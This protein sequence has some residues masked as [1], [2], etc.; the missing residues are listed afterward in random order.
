MCVALVETDPT[1]ARPSL[2]IECTPYLFPNFLCLLNSLVSMKQEI[3][4][5]LAE[6]SYRATET[7]QWMRSLGKNCIDALVKVSNQYKYMSTSFSPAH[8]FRKPCHS[9]EKREPLS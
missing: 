5:L 6:E 4:Q 1:P 2:R 3:D 8:L 7:G 9:R